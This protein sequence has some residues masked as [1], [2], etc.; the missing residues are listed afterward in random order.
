MST[1]LSRC[2]DV[3]NADIVTAPTFWIG[4]CLCIN[5]YHISFSVNTVREF[6]AVKIV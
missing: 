3:H 6:L 2:G 5:T 1:E 4:L